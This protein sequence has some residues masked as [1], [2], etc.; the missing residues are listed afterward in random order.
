MDV[1]G[2]NIYAQ[3]DSV[4][5]TLVIS[6]KFTGDLASNTVEVSLPY[7][8]PKCYALQV[9]H[10]SMV[11]DGTPLP[12]NPNGDL[13][14]LRSA[15]LCSGQGKNR[16]FMSQ[17]DDLRAFQMDTYTNV[18]AWTVSGRKNTTVDFYPLGLPQSN[19]KIFLDAEQA[20]QRFQLNIDNINGTIHPHTTSYTLQVVMTL[21]SRY[22]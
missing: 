5:N 2:G 4:V 7:Q 22:Q 20:V 6:A 13:L 16:Y 17:T 15:N 1:D 19:R 11:D 9:E 10:F 18:L 14:I 21:Y 12:I 3:Y 8:I